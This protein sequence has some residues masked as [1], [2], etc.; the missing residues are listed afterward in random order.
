MIQCRNCL[1]PFPVRETVEGECAGC[2][3]Y[4][5][6]QLRRRAERAESRIRID[7]DGDLRILAA[8]VHACGGTAKVSNEALEYAPNLILTRYDDPV[9]RCVVFTAMPKTAKAIG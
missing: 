8:M 7:G 1:A 5:M 9:R 2:A 4:T 6:S 3:T